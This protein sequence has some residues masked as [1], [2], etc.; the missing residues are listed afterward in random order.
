MEVSAVG[1]QTLIELI[2]TTH[3][4]EH[5]KEILVT[6]GMG[7]ILSAFVKIHNFRITIGLLWKIIIIT[8][9]DK[10]IISIKSPKVADIESN[11]MSL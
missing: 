6:Q 11:S 9:L 8:D 4:P 7:G 5:L 1:C 10:C 3:I 2:A